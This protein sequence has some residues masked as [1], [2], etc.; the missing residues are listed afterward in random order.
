MVING[1]QTWSIMVGSGFITRLISKEHEDVVE[2]EEDAGEAFG[3][4]LD[5]VQGFILAMSHEH[6]AEADGQ[7]QDRQ[8]QTNLLHLHN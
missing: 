6:R 1:E 2:D 7:K 5:D 4:P 8:Q 3:D